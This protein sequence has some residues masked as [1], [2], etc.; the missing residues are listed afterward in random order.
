MCEQRERL[1]SSAPISSHSD[2]VME[3][4]PARPLSAPAPTGHVHHNIGSI[5]SP[6]SLSEEPEGD[7]AMQQNTLPACNYQHY[8]S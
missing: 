4:L 1:N 2:H 8:N 3:L 6:I 7:E 5:A